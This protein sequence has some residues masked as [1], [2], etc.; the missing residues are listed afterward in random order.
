M[1]NTHG[2]LGKILSYFTYM[3]LIIQ[4]TLATRRL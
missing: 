3:H 2:L 1:T 4:L